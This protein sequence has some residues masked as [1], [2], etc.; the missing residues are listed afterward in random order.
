MTFG[1]VG[2]LIGLIIKMLLSHSLTNFI[3]CRFHFLFFFG[4]CADRKDVVGTYIQFSS[5]FTI[6]VTLGALQRQRLNPPLSRVTQLPF[7]SRKP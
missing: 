1:F 2:G 3:A 5:A 7:I 4:L 6:N